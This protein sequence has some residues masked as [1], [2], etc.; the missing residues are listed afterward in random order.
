MPKKI[1]LFALCCLHFNLCTPSDYVYPEHVTLCTSSDGI[2]YKKIKYADEKTDQLINLL[3]ITTKENFPLNKGKISSLI[4]QGANLNAQNLSGLTPLMAAKLVEI[5]ELLIN[6]GADVHFRNSNGSNVL[7]TTALH[8]RGYKLLAF[9]CN[10][11]VAIQNDSDDSSPLHNLC[12]DV[13]RVDKK[14]FKEAAV[15]LFAKADPNA[16]NNTGERTPRYALQRYFPDK[17]PEFDATV[18]ATSQVRAL[19][20]TET[21]NARTPF[22]IQHLPVACAGIVNDYGDDAFWD[23]TCLLEI[24][25]RAQQIKKIGQT[26]I[27]TSSKQ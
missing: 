8:R 21:D 13:H 10:R 5:A 19:K 24:Q 12:V 20:K 7:H 9:F 17:V 27:T 16:K 4:E 25:K 22:L 18:V 11:E 6:N 2:T 1:L 3:K 26:N 15:L 23:D 14:F